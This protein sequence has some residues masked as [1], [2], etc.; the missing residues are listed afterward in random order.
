[1][2]FTFTWIPYLMVHF[3]NFT[4]KLDFS[5]NYFM[6]TFFLAL[7]AATP[8]LNTITRIAFDPSLYQKLFKRNRVKVSFTLINIHSLAEIYPC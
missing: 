6:K 5:G 8:L 2:I 4:L 1:M 3:L 7:V